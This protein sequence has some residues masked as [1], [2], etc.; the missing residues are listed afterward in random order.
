M[1]I[2]L[3]ISLSTGARPS[4]CSSLCTADSIDALLLARAAREVVVAAQLVEHGAADALGREGLELHALG[5]VEARQ[6]VGQAD[7]ADLDQVVDLDVG[8]QLGDHLVGQAPHQRA[9]L[10]QRRVQVQLAF[11]GVHGSSGNQLRTRGRWRP[12]RREVGRR[13]PGH[14]L[15]AERGCAHQ[16][17]AAPGS[18]ARWR[19]RPGRSRAQSRS[20]APRKLV[21]AG[22]H[23]RGDALGARRVRRG[24]E[25]QV[26]HR[27]GRR[28]A[29]AASSPRRRGSR[30]RAGRRRAAA[31]TAPRLRRCRRG[32]ARTA[33][34]APARWRG[35]ARRRPAARP[36]RSPA[37]GPAVEPGE[38]TKRIGR[39]RAGR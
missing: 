18:A 8:R 31:G 38:S 5:R 16:P 10:L 2:S 25:Q 21:G 28:A 15:G 14:R 17:G 27:A 6:R 37:A 1:P 32:A 4:F 19:R 26:E 12:W 30:C 33:G 7:H 24:A 34:R 11:G 20:T 9:V 36:R 23:L 39:P 13:R 29:S 35:R 3:A 22:R